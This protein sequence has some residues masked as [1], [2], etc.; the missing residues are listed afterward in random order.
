MA[1]GPEHHKVTVDLSVAS[2]DVEQ[3][4]FALG[5]PDDDDI[6]PF[7]GAIAQTASEMLLD[8][9]LGRAEY[10]TKTAARQTRLFKL[11]THAFGDRM[12]PATLV[13]ALFHVTPQ[14]A[15]T[16]IATTSA[17]Y[18]RQ[19][20]DATANAVRASLNGQLKVRKAEKTADDNTYWFQCPDIGVVRAIR[21]ALASSSE[22]VRPLA[23]DST[24]TNVYDIHA[25][26]IPVITRSFGLTRDEMLTAEARA[27]VAKQKSS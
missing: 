11:I 1:D 14:A 17:R 22:P 16:L 26:A 13:A 18:A 23:R 20:A 12:P 10:P 8:E 15:G 25:S 2:E 9:V 19:L 24:A 21:T 7:V 4:R 3:L 5:L 27:R 6:G